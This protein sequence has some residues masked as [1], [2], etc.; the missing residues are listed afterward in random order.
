MVLGGDSC[1]EGCG[2]KSQHHILDGHFFK[3]ICCKN[4][5][6]VLKRRKLTKKMSGMMAHLKK[7]L[8]SG[9]GCGPVV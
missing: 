3:F 6:V 7:K 8:G 5:N 2:F 1:S 4:C 9:S